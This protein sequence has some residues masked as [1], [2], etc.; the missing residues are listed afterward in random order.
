MACHPENHELSDMTEPY[1][2]S[3]KESIHHK[4]DA[5]IFRQ[6]RILFSTLLHNELTL[7]FG[8][9]KAYIKCQLHGQYWISWS[10]SNSIGVVFHLYLL[11]QYDQ[12]GIVRDF[13]YSSFQ[14]MFVIIYFLKKGFVID[15]AYMFAPTFQITITRSCIMSIYNTTDAYQIGRSDIPWC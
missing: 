14:S 15:M 1:Q 8:A 7:L 6:Y 9:A 5:F 2:A 10:V 12:V 3:I 13:E 4:S 11:S